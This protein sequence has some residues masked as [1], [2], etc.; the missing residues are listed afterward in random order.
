MPKELSDLLYMV[1]TKH[2]YQRE[3]IHFFIYELLKSKYP[4]DIETLADY[5]ETRWMDDHE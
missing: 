3:Q 2:G 5:M 4:E 1:L